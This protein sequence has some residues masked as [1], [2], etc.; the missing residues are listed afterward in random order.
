MIPELE[1]CD[2]MI[3][4]TVSKVNVGSFRFQPKMG[5]ITFTITKLERNEQWSILPPQV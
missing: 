2:W 5:A 1:K 4:V 3:A